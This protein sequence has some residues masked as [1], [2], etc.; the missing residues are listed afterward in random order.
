MSRHHPK[1][2]WPLKQG[3]SFSQSYPIVSI[4]IL[5]SFTPKWHTYKA[6][7]IK[8]IDPRCWPAV[9]AGSDHYFPLRL[10]ILLPQ[11]LKIITACRNCGH[12]KFL[13]NIWFKLYLL[14]KAFHQASGHTMLKKE[15]FVI[16]IQ[17]ITKCTK[18]LFK[19]LILACSC[20]FSPNECLKYEVN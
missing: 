1:S 9:T 11:N 15:N 13:F 5:S 14:Q 2:Q 6:W 17:L 18:K 8:Y 19:N 16:I 7:D 20:L 3:R 10:S 4:S 12:T